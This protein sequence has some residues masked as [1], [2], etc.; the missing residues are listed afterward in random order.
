MACWSPSHVS[1]LSLA[2]D[3]MAPLIDA[4]Q[5]SPADPAICLWDAWPILTRDRKQ[6]VPDLWMALA[7]PWFADPEERHRHARIHLLER[8]PT[9]WR[10][11]GPAMP[12]GFSPG[13]RE[14][15]GSAVLDEDG[16]T[17]TL[18]FTATGRRDE[19]ALSFEQRL[20]EAEASLRSDQRG[21]RLDD[22]RGLT[23]S[24]VRD[25][26]LYMDPQAGKGAVGTIKAFRDPGYFHDVRSGR[27]FLFFTASMAGSSSPFNGAIG[28]AVARNQAPSDWR[29]LPPIIGADRLNNELER[30]HIVPFGGFY[31]LF[32][33][34]QSHVFNPYGPVGVTGL[35]G[36]VSDDLM[37]GWRPLNGSGLV[38]ANPPEAPRQAYS[39]YVLPDLTVT[40][41]V[42]NWSHD[43][44]AKEAACFGGRFAPFLRLELDGAATRLVPES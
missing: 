14:W 35:Y 15:S 33:S 40:S 16:K 41:F 4:R 2:P 28:A 32:W 19:T 1:G 26:G 38:I 43:P 42:D 25:P 27:H 29:I 20:F 39:W 24:V 34:T 30:P 23:E 8:A 44:S 3:C 9:R 31:Y 22:W 6:A 37:G 36:M 18:Y 21:W 11:Y 5:F 7:S 17:V 10:S 12:D 13:S